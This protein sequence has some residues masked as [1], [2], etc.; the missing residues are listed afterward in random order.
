MI[1][2]GDCLKIMPTLPDIDL[3]VTSPPYNVGKEYEEELVLEEYL[4]FMEVFAGVV[5]SILSDDG[6]L[7][8]NVANTGRKP[9]ISLA[10]HLT[11]TMLTVGFKMRGEI[12]WDKGASVG[13][14]T[15]WG[16]WRSASNPVLRDVHEHI[17]VFSKNGMG[18]KT[19]GVST[20][21]ADEFTEYTK[22]VWRFNTVSAKKTGHPAPFPVALP[23]RCIKLYSFENDVVLDPFA[24]SGT[25]AIACLNTNRN[26][27]LIEKEK[28]YINIINKRIAEHE[29]QTALWGDK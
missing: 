12:I 1:I 2:H 23:E 7:C 22:S 21:T 19:K 17:L 28:E 27:I 15:A 18:K 25:T 29:T 24:G 4:Q 16:S 6:R 11:T 8:L 10:T 20:L 3:V 26:Y 5:Y 13:S 9:Y 14:S